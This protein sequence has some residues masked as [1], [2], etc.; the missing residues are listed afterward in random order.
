MDD[1]EA[2]CLGDAGFARWRDI[3]GVICFKFETS[4]MQFYVGGQ[5]AFGARLVLLA[6]ISYSVLQDRVPGG[7]GV[8]SHLFGVL[9]VDVGSGGI[10]LAG[11]VVAVFSAWLSRGGDGA[12]SDTGA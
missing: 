8:F 5:V 4:K 6:V 11:D 12:G 2:L 7:C 1:E 3:V 9:C 10:G